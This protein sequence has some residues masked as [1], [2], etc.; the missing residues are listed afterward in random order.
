MTTLYVKETGSCVRR[1]GQRLEI[2]KNG[3]TL[4]SARLRDVERV[5]LF[6]NV[7]LSAP[8]MCAL[9]DAGIETTLLSYYGR[10]R[11][12]LVPAEGKNV[13]LRQKQFARYGDMAFRVGTAQKIL[14]AKVRNGRALLQRH[15]W[16]YALPELPDVMELMAQGRERI[17][18]QTTLDTLLGMEGNCARV[19]FGAF[20]KIVRTEFAF[21]TRSRRPPRDP[22]NALL[23]FG[24]S[25]L[26]SELTGVVASQG[27]DPHVGVLHEL[28]YG[29]PSLAL[30]IEE[31][32]RQPIVD[33]LVLS[34]V[35]RSVLRPEHFED[36]GEAGVF[37]NDE[38][39]PRFLECYH[40]I[41]ETEFVL[42]P[43]E[44]KTT[45][46]ALL[47]RQANSMRKAIE[48]A[49]EYVPYEVNL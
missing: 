33:R 15:H 41:M 17:F 30:D 32:F 2:V 20:G 42:K 18:E 49:E 22:V 11:G 5:V 35:N 26:C 43:T 37:L 4:A 40:R 28:D 23:S 24:Y 31:E 3:A 36:R 14:G 38:G 19:Y 8:A 6:G 9:L 25:L 48:G 46:H 44:E 10:F 1:V 13:F 27:L 12:R 21:T 47:L 34:V 29:R 45:Y 7:E 39:R 16:D